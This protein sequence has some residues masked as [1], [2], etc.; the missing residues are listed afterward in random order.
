LTPLRRVKKGGHGVVIRDEIERLSL[1]L[2]LERRADH[3]EKISEMNRAGWL[4]AR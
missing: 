4:N 2:E 3:P 1:V